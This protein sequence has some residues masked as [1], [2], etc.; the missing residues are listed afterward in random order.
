MKLLEEKIFNTYLFVKIPE[1]ERRFTLLWDVDYCLLSCVEGWF[2]IAQSWVV[3]RHQVEY[4]LLTTQAPS[5]TTKS[6]HYQIKTINYLLI[7][8]EER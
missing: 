7:L 6:R 4:L 2:Y 3:I 1:M 8:I 5:V